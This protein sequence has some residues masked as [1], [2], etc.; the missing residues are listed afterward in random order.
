MPLSPP[1][2]REEKHVRET[3]C[4]GYRRA[5][6]YWDIEA[7]ILDV[8]NEALA[9]VERG[10]PIPAGEP[11]HKMHVRLTI[12]ESYLIH[13]AEVAFENAP[14]AICGGIA[15]VFSALEGM[16]IGPGF[17]R[18]IRERFGGT[19]GCTHVVDLMRPLAV[20]AWQTLLPHA[21]EKGETGARIFDTC[22][23]L[24]TDGSLVARYWP[25]FARGSKG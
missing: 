1:V 5:D 12:D 11:I 7:E 16:T 13:K 24:A 10:A 23:A 20:I 8:K 19:L 4:R 14:F 9:N 2:P 3:I 6:G 18:E 21:L 17:L 15:P 25:E 22:H